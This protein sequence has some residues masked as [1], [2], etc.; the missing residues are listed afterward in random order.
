MIMDCGPQFS[1]HDYTQLFSLYNRSGVGKTETQL[2]TQL[3]RL[4]NILTDF[5]TPA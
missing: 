1:E 3:D 2:L 4:K 5:E